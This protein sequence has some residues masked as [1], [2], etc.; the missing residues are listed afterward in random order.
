MEVVLHPAGQPSGLADTVARHLLTVSGMA[1]G[2]IQKTGWLPA[3]RT[4]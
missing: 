4:D 1:E 3:N 2:L